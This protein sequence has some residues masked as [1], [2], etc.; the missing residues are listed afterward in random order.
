MPAAIVAIGASAGGLEALEQ[1]FTHMPPNTG[2]AFVVILHQDPRQKGMLTEILERYTSMP[3]VEVS[4]NIQTEP[5]TVYVKP[6]NADIAILQGVL[7][8]LEM[9]PDRGLHLPIDIFFRHLAEDQD[10]MAVGILLSGTGTDGTLGIRALKE[11]AGMIMVQDPLSTNFGGMPQSAIATGLVDYVAQPP[12]LPELLIKYVQNLAQMP[13]VMKIPNLA[14]ENEL[15]RIFI[16]LRSRSGQD[17]SQ[18]KRS[19]IQRRIGRRMSLHQLTR[20]EDYVHYLQENPAEIE[21]LAKELLIGVTQFFRDPDAWE[22]LKES[23]SGLIKRTPAGSTLRAWVVGCSTGEEAYTMAIVF[24]EALDAL[25]RSGEI[26]YQVFG[27]D[28]DRGAI[29]IARHGVYSANITVD[30]SPERLDRFFIREDDTFMIRPEVRE[31]VVFAP[32]N[33]LTDPPFT[34]LDALSCRNLLI[35]L[36]PELQ[37]KLITL[38][39]YALNPGGIL[40]LGTAESISGHRDLFQALENKWKIFQQRGVVPPF[41]IHPELPLHFT[42]P[43]RRAGRV[44]AGREVPGQILVQKW[45]FERFVPPSVIV[46]ENGDILYFQGKTRKYL[47]PPSGKANLNVNAMA[48][49]G[50]QFALLSA[51]GA[52][53]REKREITRDDLFV[54]TDGRS[55][56]IRL[57]VQPIPETAEPGQL[58]LIIFED[59]PEPA[60]PP[61]PE[62]PGDLPADARYTALE[63]EVLHS[64]QQLQ[65]TVEQ[66]QA[67]Q[68][69]LRSANEE[70]QSTNEELISSKEELQSLNEELITVNAEYQKKIEELSQSTDD[71]RNVLRSTE[72][73]ILFLDN[74]LRVRRF[75]EPIRAVI[76]LQSSDLN[77]PITDL[78]VNLKDERFLA[79]IRG[80]LDTLQMRVKQVQ[81]EE[82]RWYEMRILPFRTMENRI[83]GVVVSFMDITALK[84]LETSLRNSR[85]YAENIIATIREPLLVLDDQLKV[86]SANRSFL[87]TFKVSQEETE[88]KY[89]YAL[90]DNQWDIPKLRQL[91][92]DVLKKQTQF[93]GY[94]MEHDFPEIGHRIMRLN[95]RKI[96]ED[97][98]EAMILLAIEDV[99]GQSPPPLQQALVK[100]EHE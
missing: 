72:I 10:G 70:L 86:I 73:P 17:F 27:T 56:R 64:R 33:V 67:S 43:D 50:L 34:R 13:A 47:E 79:D 77:R 58:Y 97:T 49:E 76:N 100:G 15:A 71:M 12:E 84:E 24:R 39:H 2:M 1:F 40:L 35:Y 20:L 69:E 37:K 99:T 36:S 14:T 68:E 74:Q 48:R 46:N 23:L 55:Q 94:E 11:H 54:Q 8:L 42:G 82:G 61:A 91:I 88:G 98:G 57:T 19:T 81:T 85:T 87:T 96:Q 52:A 45:L 92:E 41:A 7:T 78:N 89:L 28:V 83:D 25:D 93:E 51:I 26:R 30:I 53:S 44:V 60:E 95:A 31:T 4:D 22:N 29:E 63:Q 3:V 32:H 80:V 16:L 66:M 62:H 90:G 38:F 18:Y 21:I 75:T 59:Q 6:S 5:N 65:D 9:G